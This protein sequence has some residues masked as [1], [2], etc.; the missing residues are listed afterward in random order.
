MKRYNGFNQMGSLY[1][2]GLYLPSGRAALYGSRCG[3]YT[4][5]Q[6]DAKA[7]AIPLGLSAKELPEHHKVI[8]STGS[9]YGH[10]HAPFTGKA[11]GMQIWFGNPIK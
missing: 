3:V 4:K 9:Y 5:N 7:L 8:N 6:G 11:H 10:Y 1:A 2:D